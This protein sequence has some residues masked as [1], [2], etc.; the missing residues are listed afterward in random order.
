M[1]SRQGEIRIKGEA[2]A[3]AGAF[4]P[5]QRAANAGDD[6]LHNDQESSLA[7]G[8]YLEKPGF[9]LTHRTRGQ[10]VGRDSILFNLILVCFNV[11]VCR[12]RRHRS[13]P[14]VFWLSFGERI[15]NTE[16]I[17]F[18]SRRGSPFLSSY[19]GIFSGRVSRYHRYRNLGELNLS[20]YRDIRRDSLS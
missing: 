10:T 9:G 1:L 18:Q 2:L 3:A 5:N 4:E 19:G 20:G 8:V 12:R 11:F 6:H 17:V 16:G 15:L 7:V 13:I 14:S